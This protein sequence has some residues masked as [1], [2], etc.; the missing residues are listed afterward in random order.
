MQK[1]IRW[2]IGTGYIT[3]SYNGQG[4]GTILVSSDDNDG[5]ARNQTVTVK[6]LDGLIVRTLTIRQS[7]R[8]FNSDFNFDFG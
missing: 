7:A 4:D 5:P 3:L 8:D 1:R 6:T 2:N